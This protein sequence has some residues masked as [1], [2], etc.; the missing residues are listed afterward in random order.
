MRP[1]PGHADGSPPTSSRSR[2]DSQSISWSPH[3]RATASSGKVSVRVRVPE[4]QIRSATPACFRNAD[5]PVTPRKRGFFLRGP[6]GFYRNRR[7]PGLQLVAAGHHAGHTTGKSANSVVGPSRKA[8]SLDPLPEKSQATSHHRLPV[9]PL[10]FPSATKRFHATPSTFSTVSHGFP[11][12]IAFF[13]P[14][15]RPRNP[16][17]PT[18]CV[19]VVFRAA[20]PTFRS[21]TVSMVPSRFAG[22]PPGP[23]RPHEPTALRPSAGRARLRTAWLRW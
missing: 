12:V 22:R 9:P 14:E 1:R 4:C 20:G 21:R 13:L 6:S 5:M 11:E 10:L 7:L 16:R 8:R 2:R 17:L 19:S 3:R 18:C 15:K 23:G